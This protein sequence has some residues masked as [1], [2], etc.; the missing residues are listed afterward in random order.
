MRSL[1]RWPAAALY[2]GL[3]V[4][5]PPGAWMSVAFVFC[6]EIDLSAMGG[7][8]FQRSPTKFVRDIECA[9]V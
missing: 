8:L 1:R 4:R 7:S 5:N 3:Q 9:E 2:L 6:C